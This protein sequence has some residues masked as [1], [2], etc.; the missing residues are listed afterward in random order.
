M[1]EPRISGSGP[2]RGRAD[3]EEGLRG[4]V[5][6][7][8]Y[9]RMYGQP[10]FASP[11]SSCH[12]N[13]RSSLFSLFNEYVDAENS[14]SRTALAKETRFTSSQTTRRSLGREQTKKRLK[15]EERR[16][17]P[18]PPR[19]T[20]PHPPHRPPS[21]SFLRPSWEFERLFTGARELAFFSSK[22]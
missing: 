13:I 22:L 15:L 18:S 12:F 11:F 4:G 2:A 3:G 20:T 5:K 16:R 1:R 7:G 17:E 10:P 19:T 6:G 9:A 8:K 21:H 14:K